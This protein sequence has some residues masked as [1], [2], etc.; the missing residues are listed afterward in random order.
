MSERRNPLRR[1]RD[2]FRI[3]VLVAAAALVVIGVALVFG[4]TA[5]AL[6]GLVFALLAGYFVLRWLQ[7]QLESPDPRD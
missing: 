1:E 3:L 4:T 6:L 5:G 7:Y 2:A